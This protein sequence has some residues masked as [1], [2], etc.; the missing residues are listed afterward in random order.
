VG[1]FLAIAAILLVTF[2]AEGVLAQAS[3]RPVANRTHVAF[4][5]SSYSNFSLDGSDPP[6]SQPTT[7]PPTTAPA[8]APDDDIWTREQLTGD[9]FG[10]R[11]D[12]ADHG[13]TLKLRLVQFYQGVAS[14]GAN[15]NFAYGGKLDYILNIDGHKLGLWEGLFVKMHAETQFGHSINGDAGAFAL[16]NTAMLYP[17]PDQHETAITGLLV[18][19]ALSKNFVLAAGKINVVDLWTMVYP[20][21]GGGID[22]FSNTNMLASALPWLRWVNLSVLGAGALVLRDDGQIQGGVVAFDTNNSTTTTGIPELFD[23]GAAVVGLWRFFFDIGE[24]PGRLLFAF[25]GSTRKYHSFEDH[26]SGWEVEGITSRILEAANNRKNGSWT[27]AIYYDQVLWQNP[28]NH[29]QDLWFFTGWSVSDGD[30]SFAKWGGFASVEATGLLFGR[31]KDRAGVGVFYNGLSSDFK[32]TMDRVG[33]NLQDTWGGELYYNVEM[34]PWF[35]LTPNLQ[36]VQNQNDDDDPAVIA[37]IRA[38]IDF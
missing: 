12:L 27:A 20:R 29:K 38:V 25:G 24:K 4:L 8:V 18:E 1:R 22:G 3:G 2:G 23:S 36:V 35:H 33:V 21:M 26:P 32:S 10:L 19:Q 5:D 17:L 28:N 7:A 31:E 30:P 34:T 13:I 16:S 14:G 11:S 15:T 37:G 9:W 6:T